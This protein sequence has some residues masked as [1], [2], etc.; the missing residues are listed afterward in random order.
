MQRCLM[1]AV[2]LA[3]VAGCTD[4][5]SRAQT[6]EVDGHRVTVEQIDRDPP[7]YRAYGASRKD[8][9]TATG[10]YFARNVIA[11]RQVSG[12]PIKP[13]RI[14]HDAERAESVATVIC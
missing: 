7:T 14:S 5:L 12:C 3:C 11:I 6:A 13:D 4:G 2:L 1:A 9:D 8:R 10:S